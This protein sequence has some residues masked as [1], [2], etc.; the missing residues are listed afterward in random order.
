MP[1]LLACSSALKIPGALGHRSEHPREGAAWLEQTPLILREHRGLN[2]LP[3]VFG[4]LADLPGA[5]SPLS[6]PLTCTGD[7]AVVSSTA[8]SR[9]S[10]AP[11]QHTGAVPLAGCI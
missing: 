3:G 4:S 10:T 8:G 1:P 6:E 5:V 7:A 11:A 2:L 9:D